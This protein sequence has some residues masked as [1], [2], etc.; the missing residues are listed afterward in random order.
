MLDDI[1]FNEAGLVPAIAQDVRSGRVLMMAWMNRQ[2]IAETVSSGFAH[3][4]SR[5]RQR[6]WKKGESSGHLQRVVA[7]HLDCDG[8]TILLQVEQSGAACHTNRPSCFY[9]TLHGDRWVTVEE[10]AP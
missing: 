7:M 8:D 10:P 5:S 6:Q 4:Y 1:T 2:A 3:Y 9:R